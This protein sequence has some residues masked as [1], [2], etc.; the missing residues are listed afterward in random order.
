MTT[1]HRNVDTVCQIA[2]LL[3]ILIKRPFVETNRE[4]LNDNYISIFMFQLTLK[5]L[6]KIYCMIIIRTT[7]FDYVGARGNL[8][9]GIYFHY[10]LSIAVHP[11]IFL[12]LW[13]YRIC[14]D[15]RRLSITILSL[16]C[17]LFFDVKKKR[18]YSE[19]KTIAWDL[20]QQLFAKEILL[21]RIGYATSRW[22]INNYMIFCAI[23]DTFD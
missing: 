7:W 15:E 19:I 20:L 1:C 22:L 13:F 21:G 23:S 3:L 6:T 4:K 11:H 8:R 9:Y 17:L 10:L 14:S 2:H 18:Q 12:D 16:V 5:I